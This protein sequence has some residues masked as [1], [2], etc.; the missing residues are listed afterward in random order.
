[1]TLKELETKFEIRNIPDCSCFFW[2]CDSWDK[3]FGR[4]ITEYWRTLGIRLRMR[5]CTAVFLY[6]AYMYYRPWNPGMRMRGHRICKHFIIRACWS[7]LKN[8]MHQA[9]HT[10]SKT[11]G[12]FTSSCFFGNS[13]DAFLPAETNSEEEEPISKTP[14]FRMF[15]YK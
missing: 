4:S 12:C 9:T 6:Y 14:R 5:T 11:N 7:R 15:S 13:T 10:L 3:S 1:M 8:G 2:S